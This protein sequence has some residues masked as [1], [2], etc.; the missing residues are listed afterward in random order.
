M[1]N[2][3][4]A[5]RRLPPGAI[6]PA[7]SQYD[8]FNEFLTKIAPLLQGRLAEENRTR[9]MS[10]R[11]R[12]NPSIPSGPRVSQIGNS[13][14]DLT[15]NSS[16][17]T[18]PLNVQYG[19]L[20]DFQR[21]QLDLRGRELDLRGD[22]LDEADR[23]GLQNQNRLAEI[24][25]RAAEQSK[26]ITQRGD[27]TSKQ[28][29]ERHLN[30]TELADEKNRLTEKL[31]NL[32][33]SQNMQEIQERGLIEER[34]TRIRAEET[35]RTQAEKPVAEKVN[36]P[37]S[38]S[39]VKTNA[40]VRFNR[41]RATNPEWKDYV[42][43]SEQGLPELTSKGDKLDEVEKRA[44]LRAFGIDEGGADKNLPNEDKKETPS[45]D[46]DAPPVGAPKGGKWVDAGKG[47][48]VYMPPKG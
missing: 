47:R 7:N 13:V 27:I 43:L 35:R 10:E 28:I 2:I 18:G 11:E 42:Q 14:I 6:P 16:A 32:R 36:R 15:K 44:V 12:M 41:V 23:L 5:S 46:T 34:L 39:I 22:K 24:A 20:T 38:A 33:G 17:N 4:R 25:A 29:E 9:I 37:D 40:Q 3:H 26:Q 45:T 8:I 19:G 30:T 1:D 48:R 31:V 21:A